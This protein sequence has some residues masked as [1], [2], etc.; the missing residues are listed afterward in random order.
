MIQLL[1]FLA[2]FSKLRS[3]GCK[4]EQ[5]QLVEIRTKYSMVTLI[6]TLY[7]ASFSVSEDL[8]EFG[9]DQCTKHNSDV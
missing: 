5:R 8:P 9:D 3:S 2:C 1:S 7:K 4:D 6:T